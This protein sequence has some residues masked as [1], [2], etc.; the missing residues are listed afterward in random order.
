MPKIDN[1][2]L[3]NNNIFDPVTYIPEY[4]K[5]DT[6]HK[7]CE[8]G[9]IISFNPLGVKVLYCRSRTIQ[10]TNPKHLVFG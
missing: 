9:V 2:E 7:D 1:I 5:G 10:L 4:A 6:S 8:R 3:T